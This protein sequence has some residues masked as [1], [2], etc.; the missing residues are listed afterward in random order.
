LPESLL[1]LY[2]GRS[3]GSCRLHLILGS[4][5]FV[6]GCERAAQIIEPAR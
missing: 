2:G 4:D 1:G 6:L 5:E 3:T